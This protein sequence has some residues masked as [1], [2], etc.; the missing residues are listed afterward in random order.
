MRNFEVVKKRFADEGGHIDIVISRI[1]KVSRALSRVKRSNIF[2][3]YFKLRLFN[4]NVLSI[5]TY[6][7][8]SW[9]VNGEQKRKI[10]AS[11]KIYLRRILNIHNRD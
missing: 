9:H 8:I 4:R 3:I 5:L 6:A 7:D 1:A 2:L 11:E 10:L